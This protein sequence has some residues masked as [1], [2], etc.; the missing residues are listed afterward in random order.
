MIYL[1]FELIGSIVW[2]SMGTLVLDDTTS[3]M[4]YNI[5]GAVELK[6][7]TTNMSRQQ[8]PFTIPRWFGTVYRDGAL[9]KT[10]A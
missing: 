10:E 9:L 4:I 3:E 7:S 6:D 8:P 2:T 5:N 1:H